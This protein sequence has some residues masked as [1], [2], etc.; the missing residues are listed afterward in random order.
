MQDASSKCHIIII[1]I[2][3]QNKNKLVTKQRLAQFLC[4]ILVHLFAMTNSYILNCTRVYLHF[5]VIG[6]LPFTVKI[7][8]VDSCNK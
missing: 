1:I 6:C 4:E 5:K 3:K 8:L 7:R 2:K